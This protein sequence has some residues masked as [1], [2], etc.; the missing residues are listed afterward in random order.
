V[1]EVAQSGRIRR[2]LALLAVALAL[3]TA[4]VPI[5]PG[6]VE[7]VYSRSVYLSFQPFLTTASNFVP[8]A[9]LDVA[10]GMILAWLGIAFVRDSRAHGVARATARSA[11]TLVVTVSVIYLLF[12]A[13][14]GLNYRRVPLE[15]KLPFDR[16]RV[17]QGGAVTLAT[18]AVERLNAGYAAAHAS[19]FRP[20]V[21][22][23]AFFHAQQLVGPAFTSATGRPKRSLA[24][25]YFR[26]SAIDGMTVPVFLEIILNPDLLPVERP[27]VLAHEW[28]HLA[29]Y[30]DESE[31]S[32]IA[33]L[34]GVRSDDAVA[35]YSAWL[36]AYSLAYNALP[37][38]VRATIPPLDEGPRR[39]LRAIA[40]RYA[41]SSA[42]VRRV[43]RGAYD[44][45]LKANRIDE[46]IQN[47]AQAL[48][49]I[50]GT[51]LGATA[52]VAVP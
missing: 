47:Y 10:V 30:A 12:L 17:T 51:D 6:W 25:L 19:A 35:R 5:S 2:F 31:A 13:T 52:A 23:Y 37:R 3:V 26:Y 48:Q 45:Y 20:D 24:G 40:A 7:R 41:R 39:D 44:S 46:G 15:A 33:W 49:L 28:A 34:A 27:S 38:H 16:S 50:L 4:F 29:G 32:F 18:T 43:A 42:A 36:D 22:E 1:D 11:I 14:W 9:L 8:I 21:L